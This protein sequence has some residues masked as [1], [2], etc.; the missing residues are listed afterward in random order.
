[1]YYKSVKKQCIL[2]QLLKGSVILN[3]TSFFVKKGCFL[4]NKL[5][6]EKGICDEGK[7]T[8]GIYGS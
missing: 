5:R 1:M 4:N 3:N 2:L 6:L 8:I 7:K